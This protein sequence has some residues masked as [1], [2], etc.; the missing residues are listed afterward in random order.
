MDDDMKLVC[1]EVLDYIVSRH[2]DLIGKQVLDKK[3]TAALDSVRCI[4]ARMH[5]YNTEMTNSALLTG[6]SRF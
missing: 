6:S 1:T 3:V 5:I 4:C 2:E